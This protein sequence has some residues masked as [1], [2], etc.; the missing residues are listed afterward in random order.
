MGDRA[1]NI[2]RAIKALGARGVRV[3]RQSSLYETEPVDVR[4]GGWFLNGVIAGGNEHAAAAIDADA[5]DHRT[6]VGAKTPGDFGRTQ[7][8]ADD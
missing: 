2:A 5:A 3:T 1:Q 4:G 7:G 6:I 8:V